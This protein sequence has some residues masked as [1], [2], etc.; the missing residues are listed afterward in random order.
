MSG[1]LFVTIGVLMPTNTLSRL[2][3]VASPSASEE[4]VDQ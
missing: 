4:V 2:A 3:T 1:L